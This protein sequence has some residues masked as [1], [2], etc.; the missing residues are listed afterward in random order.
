MEVRQQ[1]KKLK[2]IDT[3]NILRSN[4]HKTALGKSNGTTSPTKDFLKWLNDNP[5]VKRK[6]RIVLDYGC[7]KGRDE[8]NIKTI[9]FKIKLVIIK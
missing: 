4:Y 2:E 9:K 8:N 5:K 7:G 1:I 6:I 3:I